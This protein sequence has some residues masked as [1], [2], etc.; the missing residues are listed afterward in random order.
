MAEAIQ[1]HADVGAWSLAALADE[2]AFDRHHV[3][4]VAAIAD[5]IGAGVH[6]DVDA[7][8]DAF[9]DWIAS[10]QAAD[11][12]E[13]DENTFIAV[14]ATLIAALARRPIVSYAWAGNEPPDRM[15]DAVLTYPNEVTALASGAAVYLLRVRALT[16][17]DPSIPLSALI[18]ENAAAN[19]RRSAEAATRFRE[20]L[21][22]TTPWC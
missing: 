22:L 3:A 9:T 11:D 18:V 20:L 16:G 10:L 4:V 5:R 19:L 7:R 1:L 15:T 14:C 12:A 13:P 21:Q 17:V 8:R 6:I 2:A